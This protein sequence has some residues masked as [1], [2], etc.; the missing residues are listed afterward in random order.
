LPCN[1]LAQ[2]APGSL[3]TGRRPDSLFSTD[4]LRLLWDDTTGVLSAPV[5]WQKND[6]GTFAAL[7]GA[8]L[9]SAGADRAVRR[10]MSWRGQ[11]TG[12]G[13]FFR[14]W[15]KLGMEYSWVELG[16]FEVWGIL[17][18]SRPASETAMDGLAASVIAGGIVTPTLK[19]AAGRLRP[20]Q[21]ERTFDFRPFSNHQSFPSGHST[22]AF[23][24]ATVVAQHYHEWWQQSLAYGSAA[25]VAVARVQQNAHYVSDVVAGAAIGWAVGRAV[26]HRN[27]TPWGAP[28]TVQPWISP[29][30]RGLIFSA[31]F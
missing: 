29:G 7:G 14:Q 2:A 26:V 13:R 28:V 25:T 24:I 4:Y 10:D 31:A 17:G 16:A 27:D 18:H 9:A 11:N 23:A 21:T 15:Q 1:L 30:G 8:T 5:H 6:W 20:N 22:Q 3:A 12:S 19:F